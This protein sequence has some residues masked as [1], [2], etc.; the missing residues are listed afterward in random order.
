MKYFIASMC[1]GLAVGIQFSKNTPNF[2]RSLASQEATH[3]DFLDLACPTETEFLLLAKK[4]HLVIPEG[5]YK[6]DDSPKSKLAR[7]LYFMDQLRTDLPQ[8]WGGAA[9]ET[10]EQPLEYV[11]KM[12]N[13]VSVDFTQKDSIAQNFRMNREIF[14]GGLFFQIEPLFS[15]AVFIHEAR[16]SEESSPGHERCRGGDI[17]KSDGGCDQTFTLGEEGGAYSYGAIFEL[18][19][20][21]YG[22]NLSFEDRE[23]LLSLALS[24][25]ASRFNEVPTHHA[26][27]TD[28]ITVLDENKDVYLVNPYSL[29][30]EKIEIPNREKVRKIDLN[31]SNAGIYIYGESGKVYTW[32]A[33][34][35]MEEPYKEQ[36][37]KLNG[38]QDIDKV[39]VPSMRYTNTLFLSTDNDIYSLDTDRITGKR[40]LSPFRM[41]PEKKIQK[42]IS[43]NGWSGFM[44]TES[45]EVLNVGG[46]PRGGGSARDYYVPYKIFSSDRWKQIH[47]GITYDQL[48]GVNTSGKVFFEGPKP[49]QSGIGPVAS[50]FQLE[51]GSQKYLE[52]T[53]LRGL[54]SLGGDLY[55]SRYGNERMEKIPIRGIGKIV[56]FAIPRK[57]FLMD[58]LKEKKASKSFEETCKVRDGIIEPILSLPLGINSK[59]ALILGENCEDLGMVGEG[60]LRFLGESYSEKTKMFSPA[61]FE[62][63]KERMMPY[64]PR[65]QK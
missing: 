15:A 24:H 9:R 37:S 18:G 62:F 43:A 64:F 51:G 59:G 8:K 60:K 12:A 25:V 34:E 26:V 49:D 65:F 53:N 48:F 13:S 57:Y 32:S 52:G 38:V 36:L 44:L 1:L 23:Y 54:L 50:Q 31:P 6:C 16:H 63:G 35:G 10:L 27:P 11:A 22:K 47:G 17:P 42:M 2:K 33:N 4:I 61:Y 21:E 58:H 5:E 29:K 39:I 55:L 20:S 3:S 40:I 19:L 30:A 7:I 56:D 45:G 41:R 14:L 28:L 46:S